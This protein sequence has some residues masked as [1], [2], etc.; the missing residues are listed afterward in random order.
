VKLNLIDKSGAWY[1]YKGDKIGQGKAN[2]GKFLEDNPAI[3][4]EIEGMI[5]EQLLTTP[6]SKEEQEAEAKASADADA[7]VLAEETVGEK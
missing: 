3:A 5:R 4:S 1:A 7:P 2:S 6:K